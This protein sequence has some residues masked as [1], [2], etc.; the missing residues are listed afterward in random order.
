ML[1]PSQLA[2]FSTQAMWLVLLLSLPSVVVA[3]VVALGV[4]IAQTATQIQ[5]QSI[6]QA[7]RQ[8]AVL[9]VVF[10]TAPW[11]AHELMSFGNRIF[12]AIAQGRLVQ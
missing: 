7:I 5:D 11:V 4:A 3:A 9:G 6:G 12:L 10:L 2:E 8:I 1:S